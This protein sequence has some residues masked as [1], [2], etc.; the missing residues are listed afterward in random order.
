MEMDDEDQQLRDEDFDADDHEFY[1]D[2]TGE[3]LD[4]EVVAASVTPARRINLL[5]WT[6]SV[7]LS[8]I[9]TTAS[10]LAARVRS[11]IANTELADFVTVL[12]IAIALCA[13]ASINLRHTGTRWRLIIDS[14]SVGDHRYTGRWKCII[15]ARRVNPVVEDFNVLS[16]S[17][18]MH[19][20]KVEKL[21]SNE[22]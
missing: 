9:R 8:V 3:K 4:K 22:L 12:G 15:N 18:V 11:T 10:T 5:A 19:T 13:S 21:Q 17:V 20:G 1:D 7:M 2:R 16:V 14:C 6:S